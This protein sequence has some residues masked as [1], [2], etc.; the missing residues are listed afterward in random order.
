[1]PNS[2]CGI[3]DSYVA[4]VVFRHLLAFAFAN[5]TRDSTPANAMIYAYILCNFQ[6]TIFNGKLKVE[7]GKLSV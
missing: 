7:N 5:A 2:S 1:M 4:I 3:L 6:C